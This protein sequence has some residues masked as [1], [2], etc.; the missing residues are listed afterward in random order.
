M[1]HVRGW[2]VDVGEEEG[3]VVVGEGD[4][5][6]EVVEAGRWSGGGLRW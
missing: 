1:F 3:E 6:W 2:G 4:G 5:G